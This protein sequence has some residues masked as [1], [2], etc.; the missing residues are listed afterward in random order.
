MNRSQ[1]I[2]RETLK[3]LTCRLRQ[4]NLCKGYTTVGTLRISNSIVYVILSFGLLVYIYLAVAFGLEYNLDL[5]VVSGALC[6]S[7]GD[8]QIF[9]IYTCWTLHRSLI[10]DSVNELQAIVNKRKLY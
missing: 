5:N 7:C 2:T 4:L 6:V 3:Y 1:F 10:E 9:L 8:F